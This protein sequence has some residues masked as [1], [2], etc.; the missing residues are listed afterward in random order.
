MFRKSQGFALLTYVIAVGALMAVLTAMM[1][2]SSNRSSVADRSW[3]T[4]AQIVAQANLIRGKLL[5]CA[6]GNGD[7]G[8][9]NHPA[10]PKDTTAGT[11]EI[12]RGGALICPASSGALL[13]GT[14]G[15]F[16]PPPPSGFVDW[17][18]TNDSTSVRIRLQA[19]NAVSAIGESDAMTK[20]KAKFGT[21]ATLQ[22][23]GATNDTFQLVVVN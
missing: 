7:N 11:W 20:A 17:Q 19:V 12:I 18:Y 8:T 2:L 5:D 6:S 15:V 3:S 13:T 14:D 23:V 10:F 16:L 22:T 9:S 4:S 1:L 21:E